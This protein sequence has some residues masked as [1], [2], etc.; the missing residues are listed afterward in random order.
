MGLICFISHLIE[1][2]KLTYFYV[3]LYNILTKLVTNQA[4][5][6]LRAVSLLHVENRHIK[7][8]VRLGKPLHVTINRL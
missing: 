4:I 3:V 2:S 1:I 7:N 5:N 8:L 6:T